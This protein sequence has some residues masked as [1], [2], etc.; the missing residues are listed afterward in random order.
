M[1]ISNVRN[2]QIVVPCCPQCGCRL[3]QW[4]WEGC[5]WVHFQGES[6]KD[7]QSHACSLYRINFWVSPKLPQNFY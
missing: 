2:G 6:G 1:E 5:F 3:M 4:G 7:A